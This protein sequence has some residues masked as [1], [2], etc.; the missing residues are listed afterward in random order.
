MTFIGVKM[1]FIDVKMAFIDVKMA[2][3]T[4]WEEEID[5]SSIL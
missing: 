4:S 5:V 3:I 2:F 1:A